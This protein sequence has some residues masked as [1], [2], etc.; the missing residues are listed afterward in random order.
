MHQ[1]RNVV[2][3]E[4]KAIGVPRGGAK[5]GVCGASDR[6]CLPSQHPPAAP[7]CLGSPPADGACAAELCQ[8]CAVQPCLRAFSGA[9]KHIGPRSCGQ[10][11]CGCIVSRTD[12]FFFLCSS[13]SCTG[14]LSRCLHA[15]LFAYLIVFQLSCSLLP[16]FC[17]I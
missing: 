9:K 7:H 8:H 4:P 1:G 17:G 13:Y 6:D 12:T 3:T 5:P 10:C 11:L 2:E 15:I 16:S 14:N